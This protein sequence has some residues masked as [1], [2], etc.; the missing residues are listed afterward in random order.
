MASDIK[1]IADMCETCKEMKP[2]SPP[3]PLKQQTDGDEPWQKIG[4][5][6][7]ET[8]GNH[9]LAVQDYYSNFIEIDS[10]MMTSALTVKSLKKHCAHYGKPRMIVSV[11]GP[12]FTSQVHSLLCRTEVQL[13]LP[14]HQWQS[15]ISH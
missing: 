6:F 8:A 12:Q 7:F 9:C 13:I 4:L 10:L 3:E 1:Q 14:H 2:Q 11:V 15:R 5:D